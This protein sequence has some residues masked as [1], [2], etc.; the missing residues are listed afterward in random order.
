MNTH[1]TLLVYS[2]L[3]P[4]CNESVKPHTPSPQ[5]LQQKN[6][7]HLLDHLSQ[8]TQ[9][10]QPYQQKEHEPHPYLTP[11][12]QQKLGDFKEWSRLWLDK[13]TNIV[14]EE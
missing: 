5:E 13:T 11:N 4:S 2:L 7:E 10:P 8:R 12:V 6:L 3:L 14:C 1:K 9:P